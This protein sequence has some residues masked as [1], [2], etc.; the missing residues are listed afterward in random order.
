MNL[1]QMK[2]KLFCVPCDATKLADGG[3]EWPVGFDKDGKPKLI[4][5]CRYCLA[6]FLG[7]VQTTNRHL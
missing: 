6:K 3:G 1:K 4:D 7:L 5:V 2:L